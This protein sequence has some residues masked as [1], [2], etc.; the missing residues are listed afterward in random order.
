[1][2]A[3]QSLAKS[4]RA[5]DQ[6]APNLLF[7][8][9]DLKAE[10]AT[11]KDEIVTAVEKVLESQQFIMGPE[12]RQLEAEIAAFVGSSFALGCASGSDALLL[13]LMALGVDSGDEVI[14][15]PFTFVATAGS[16]SRLKA[17]PVF[18]DINRETYNLNPTCLEAAITSRT[19]AIMPVHLF[20]LA[21]DMEK[22]S[23]IARAHRLP[24]IEDAAQSIGARYHDQYVGNL[25][26]CGCFSFFP[27][28]NLG[29]AGDGG[30]ITTSDPELTE[31]ISM[32]RD[33][34]S[35]QKYHYDLLGMNSR[36]DSLQAA[37]LLVKFNHLEA[38]TQARRRNADRYRQLFRQAGLEKLIALPVQPEGLHHVYNQFAIRTP[39]RDQLRD[40]LRHCGIPT[41]IYYPSPLHLQPAFADLGY[42]PGAFPECENASRQVLALPVFPQMTEEQ[43][44][45]VADRTAD[46]FAG[47]T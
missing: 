38:M 4:P 30:M 22:I 18:V 24:V 31:R 40:H 45:M 25:G 23:E 11:M 36:L 41:E 47:R 9:L 34:G 26:A 21:A 42:R 39:E 2:N 17:R 15:P 27:S 46:F 1:M 35:R 6:V 10:Y 28:K 37:I 14:T 13:A 32:L 20:G 44:K 16:I 29:G 7:P 12:V 33:H 19:K 43:Q 3:R 8:F 5:P